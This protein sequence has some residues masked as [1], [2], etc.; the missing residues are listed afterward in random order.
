[1]RVGVVTDHVPF[2]RGGAE[3]LLED[4][5]EAL[6][7]CG[8]E[9]AVVR[10]PWKWH[11]SDA[12]LRSIAVARLIDLSSEL[13]VPAELIIGLKFPA[14]LLPHSRKVVWLVHQHRS[15]YDLWWNVFGLSQAPEGQ[16]IAEAVIRADR[17]AMTEARR[18]FA[19]SANVAR[20]LQDSLGLAAEVLRPP[21]RREELYR[22]HSFE[23]YL[24][25]PSR[26][27]PLKRHSLVLRALRL[28]EHPVELHIA[29]APDHL[30][31]IRALEREVA[32][33]DL[34]DRVRWLGHLEEPELRRRYSRCRAVVFPPF[35]ED[36]GYVALEALLSGKPVITCTDS[37]GVVDT[38]GDSGAGWI[39]EP[40]PRALAAAMDEAWE[41]HQVCRSRGEVGPHRYR[42]LCPGWEAIVESLLCA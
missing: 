41:D 3:I 5:V 16:S 7:R 31:M 25:F 20:R 26:I 8:H 36:Y 19:I 11:P 30:G 21:V 37:G 38:L 9:V 13:D 15:V 23:P 28:T 6:A 12:I 33:L 24:F 29:G 14:Y 1:M 35:D 42:E 4:L 17:S 22:C 34:E 2:I 18:R 40:S 39:V 32:E 10:L 27:S